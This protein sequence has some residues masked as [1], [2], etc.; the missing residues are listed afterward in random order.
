MAKSEA[1]SH[2]EADHLSAVAARVRATLAGGPPKAMKKLD[3]YLGPPHKVRDQRIT[4]FSTERLTAYIR[5]RAATV[6]ERLTR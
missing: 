4:G 3:A 1:S 2:M 5:Y 6:R